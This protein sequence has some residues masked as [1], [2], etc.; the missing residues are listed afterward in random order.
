MDDVLAWLVVLLITAI[1]VVGTLTAVIFIVIAVSGA[2][3]LLLPGMLFGFVRSY[4]HKRNRE[5]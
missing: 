1:T 3:L 4:R 5:N 2:V